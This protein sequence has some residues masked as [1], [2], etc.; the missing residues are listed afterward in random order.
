MFDNCCRIPVF[1]NRLYVVGAFR[2]KRSLWTFAFTFLKNAEPRVKR[3][4]VPFVLLAVQ[5]IYYHQHLHENLHKL[6]AV[7]SHLS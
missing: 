3:P 7:T 2:Y 4:L 5:L 1:H 6:H